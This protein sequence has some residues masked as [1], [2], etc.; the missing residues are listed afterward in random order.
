[1]TVARTAVDGYVPIRNAIV[2]IH[3]GLRR[4]FAAPT[5]SKQKIAKRTKFRSANLQ[6]LFPSFASVHHIR[7]IC[8]TC[9]A[10]VRQ[11]AGRR[12]IRG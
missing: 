7:D 2:Q 1:M 8:V 4:F 11:A 10:E 3:R 5:D 12:R 9:R 6:S